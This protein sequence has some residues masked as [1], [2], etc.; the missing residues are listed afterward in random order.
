[1]PT[2]KRVLVTGASGFVGRVVQDHWADIVCWPKGTDL[3]DAT[4][5]AQTVQ[6]LMA[7]KPFDAVL[8][9][10]AEASPRRALGEVSRTWRVN[11]LGTVNLLE[12]LTALSWQGKFLYVSTGA[13]YGDRTGHITEQSP[14]QATSPY[15]ATK[16]AAEMATL[17]WG[18]RTG[19]QALVVRPFNHSG[20]GQSTHYFLASMA[21]QIAE[22]PESGGTI[23][24][25]NLDVYRDFLHVKDVVDAYRAL[26]EQGKDQEIYN[27][28]SG[29]SRPLHQFLKRLVKTSARPVQCRVAPERYREADTQPMLVEVEKLKGHT[30]WEPR[31]GW[32]CMTDEVM[33]EWM[34]STCQKQR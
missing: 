9:L 2:M 8:H 30:G 19:N 11:T 15:V 16:L 28:A 18:R 22:L 12:S 20:L 5:T 3:S 31:V 13:V 33:Q 26:L 27:L 24:V 25:G 32:E 7:T 34:E 4:L 21:S 1:M 23:D 29:Q 10:A 14:A 17:E 6:T